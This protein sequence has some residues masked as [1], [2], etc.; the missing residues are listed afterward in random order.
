LACKWRRLKNRRTCSTTNRVVEQVYLL[1]KRNI[2]KNLESQISYCQTDPD[3]YEAY[4]LEDPGDP[5]GLVVVKDDVLTFTW[6]REKSNENLIDTRDNKKGFSFYFARGVYYDEYKIKDN[7]LASD[8]RNTGILGMVDELDKK[9][10]I[11]INVKKTLMSQI[12]YT[13]VCTRDL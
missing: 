11:V 10:M 1:K 5:N 8:K 3:S 4:Y 2:M 12:K 9:V 6:Y 13:Y 7:D